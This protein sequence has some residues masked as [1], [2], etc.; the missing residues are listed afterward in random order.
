MKWKAADCRTPSARKKQKSPPP[1]Q[2]GKR[3]RK[4]RME[5]IGLVLVG[6]MLSGGIVSY[7]QQHAHEQATPPNASAATQEEEK[8]IFCPTMKTGQ[9]C[10]H[11]TAANLRLTGEKQEPWIALARKYNRTVNTATEELFKNAESILTPQQLSLLKAWFAIGLNPGINKLL[12]GK[13][14]PLQT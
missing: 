1:Q 12:Y 8:V 9:L 11:G 4:R 10:L 5:T 7:A 6:L 14:L 3:D 2:G 13:G